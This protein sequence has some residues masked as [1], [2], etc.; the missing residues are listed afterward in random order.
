MTLPHGFGKGGA[1]SERQR[2]PKCGLG[3]N[4]GDRNYVKCIVHR[5][6][7]LFLGLF[8][9]V[10]IILC[11]SG[12]FVYD[13]NYH[14][15]LYPTIEGFNCK[16]LSEYIADQDDHYKYAEHRYEWLCVNEQIK[17]FQP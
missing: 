7:V 12:Y 15:Q 13:M 5:N 11:I 9:I 3:L 17:E 8:V 4:C 10:G 16:Q 6:V 14:N 2:E 1:T